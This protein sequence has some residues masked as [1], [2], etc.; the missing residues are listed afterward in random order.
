MMSSL[1]ALA[2]CVVLVLSAF[3][4][5]EPKPGWESWIA[6]DARQALVGQGGGIRLPEACLPELNVPLASLGDSFSNLLSQFD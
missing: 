3:A 1:P 4:P 2:L 6:F 5:N